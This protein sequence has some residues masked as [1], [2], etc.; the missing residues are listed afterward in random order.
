MSGKYIFY[1]LSFLVA[2]STTESTAF[3]GRYS[4]GLSIEDQTSQ[5]I[6]HTVTSFELSSF[7][8]SV[9]GETV[10]LKWATTNEN[11]LNHFEIERSEDQLTVKV[12]GLVL[13]GF[14]NSSSGKN[15][16]FKEQL[17]GTK[18][19]YRLKGIDKN[20]RISYSQWLMVKKDEPVTRKRRRSWESDMCNAGSVQQQRLSTHSTIS[21][22]CT[23]CTTAGFGKKL[24]AVEWTNHGRA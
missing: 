19:Y 11:G 20:G 7:G 2:L 10:L 17:A 22:G 21:I 15:Y 1:S 14:S 13:D 23:G 24:Y 6:Q 16:Q 9:S 4:G 3:A 18:Y 12:T 8:F 5:H